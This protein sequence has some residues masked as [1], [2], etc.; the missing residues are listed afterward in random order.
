MAK[1]ILKRSTVKRIKA[2]LME[3]VSEFWPKGSKRSREQSVRWLMEKDN[4]NTEPWL[5]KM[6]EEALI[7][8]GPT[9]VKMESGKVLSVQLNRVKMTEQ[10]ALEYKIYREA[11]KLHGVEPVRSDFLLYKMPKSVLREME[12]EQNEKEH[13]RRAKAF[14]AASGR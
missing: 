11:C 14:A 6:L 10:Q 13:D 1:S 2:V 12:L 3:L 4:L 9:E 7:E 8:G 5:K